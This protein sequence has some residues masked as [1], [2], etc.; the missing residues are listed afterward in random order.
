MH[1]DIKTDTP[2]VGGN[3]KCARACIP[4]RKDQGSIH[5]AVVPRRSSPLEVRQ[6]KA[7]SS[8]VHAP[9][10][11]LAGLKCAWEP[12]HCGGGMQKRQGM[13]RGVRKPSSYPGQPAR[14]PR[15]VVH[16]PQPP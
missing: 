6:Y 4:G 2:Y 14:W 7:W 3:V 1:L 13:Q 12:I 16:R 15:A 10:S 9:A 5:P 8:R 11:Q